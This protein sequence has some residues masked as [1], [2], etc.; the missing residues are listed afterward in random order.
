ML[1]M[2]VLQYRECCVKLTSILWLQTKQQI[3]DRGNFQHQSQFPEVHSISLKLHDDNDD[4]DDDDD[5][6]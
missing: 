3:K 5:I 6:I 1:R 2:M 4:N